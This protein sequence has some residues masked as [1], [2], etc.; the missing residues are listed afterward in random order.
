MS[1][2]SCVKIEQND[3]LEKLF[4]LLQEMVI[5][6]LLNI[7]AEIVLTGLFNRPNYIGSLEFL[8]S[9]CTDYNI[10]TANIVWVGL[11]LDLHRSALIARF[12]PNKINKPS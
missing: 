6:M 2:S 11:L 5:K 3:L 12:L 4:L 8:L 9:S 7:C 1:F 10:I